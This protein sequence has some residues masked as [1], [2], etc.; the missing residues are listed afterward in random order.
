MS[1]QRLPQIGVP[2]GIVM[3]IVTSSA[4]EAAEQGIPGGMGGVSSLVAPVAPLAIALDAMRRARDSWVDPYA[5]GE[6]IRAAAL[7]SAMLFLTL[8]LS[9][10]GAVRTPTRVSGRRAKMALM[11]SMERDAW[12]NPWPEM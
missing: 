3:I 9:P 11:T 10:M 4:S 1:L 8:A 6:S 7:A 12:P 2:V 5:H